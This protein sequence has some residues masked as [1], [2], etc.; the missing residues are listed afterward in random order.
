[1][2]KLFSPT[3]VGVLVGLVVTVAFIWCY[4]MITTHVGSNRPARATQ[5]DVQVKVRDYFN[6]AM[7]E[8][9]EYS[10]PEAPAPADSCCFLY[11]T[12][13][14]GGKEYTYVCLVARQP[15]MKEYVIRRDLVGYSRYEG[16][17]WRG[18]GEIT[19]EGYIFTK[20]TAHFEIGEN[21]ATVT[22][23]RHVKL[24]DLV[25]VLLLFSLADIA[26]RG[27]RRMSLKKKAD[28]STAK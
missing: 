16:A 26:G 15:L 7:P 3:L 14:E 18:S 11:G 20:Y 17:D 23:E 8:S 24:L 25:S 19:A 10:L 28:G 13:T 27:F 4:G 6:E 22:Y 2:K 5:D 1:M 21:G 12:C 9:V